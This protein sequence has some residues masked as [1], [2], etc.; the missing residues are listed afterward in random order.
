MLLVVGALPLGDTPRNWPETLG[1]AAAVAVVNSEFLDFRTAEAGNPRTLSM[2]AGIADSRVLGVQDE[3]T[4]LLP[5]P[6]RVSGL[7][8]GLGREIF[9]VGII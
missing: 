8:S 9:V 4:R 1:A 7:Y 3:L 6:R 2:E 5:P